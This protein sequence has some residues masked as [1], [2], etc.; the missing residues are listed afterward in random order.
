MESLTSKCNELEV[1]WKNLGRLNKVENKIA[2][3]NFRS[4]LNDF[5]Q[6]KNAFYKEK[7]SE[8][9]KVLEIKVGICEES[10]KGSS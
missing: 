8:N 10:A 4:S 5:Y 1:E 7:K 9:N 3:V 6:K 2:W